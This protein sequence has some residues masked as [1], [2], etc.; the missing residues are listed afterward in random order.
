MIS[1][2][3]PFRRFVL[4]RDCRKLRA[5]IESGLMDAFV[6]TLLKAMRL[7]LLVDRD[8]RRNIDG[9]EGRY[10]FATQDGTIACSAVFSGGEMS[11]RPEEI[12]PTD[13]TI[14]FKSGD[15]LMKFL[16]QRNPDIINAIF[17]NDVTFDGN[18]NYVIKLAYMAKHMQLMFNI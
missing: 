8:F 4:A 11:V 15:A 17:E 5:A 1:I 6:E 13:V 2:L 3:N 7:L 18:L 12:A 16:F 14:R 10:A 9:F